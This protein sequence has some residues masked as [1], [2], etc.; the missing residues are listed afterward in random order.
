MKT[1]TSLLRSRF[2]ISAASV[3]SL[4]LAGS[5]CAK[6]V[7]VSVAV[8]TQGLNLRQPADAGK[9]YAR[10]K[11]AAW[12]VCMNAERVNLEPV[13]FKRECIE[14][15]LGDAVRSV[16]VPTLTAIYLSTHT[17]AEAAALGIDAPTRIAAK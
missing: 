17:P 1:K 5:V 9:F 16:N 14:K 13:Y 6:E 11:A 7:T 12:T 3:A 2:L 8:S 10:L 4:L 15:A